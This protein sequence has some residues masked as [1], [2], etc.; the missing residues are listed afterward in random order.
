MHYYDI[1]IVLLLRTMLIFIL[2]ISHIE[3]NILLNKFIQF[4]WQKSIRWTVQYPFSIFYSWS[5]FSHVQIYVNISLSFYNSPSLFLFLS[6]SL[7]FP[8][9]LSFYLSISLSLF[10]SICL[11]LSF[12][13]SVSLSLSHTHTGLLVSQITDE[14]ACNLLID[15]N[16]VLESQRN[17]GDLHCT[18]LY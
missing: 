10:L 16:A 7:S 14:M 1:L 13:L 11:S 6:L 3:G 15:S 8:I 4:T 5:Y 17:L 9:C 12:S 2:F 18:L